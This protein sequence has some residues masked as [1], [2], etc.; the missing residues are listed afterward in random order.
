MMDRD[1]AKKAVAPFVDM[2]EK[3][4]KINAFD[5]DTVRYSLV[6]DANALH[7]LGPE[8]FA[9]LKAHAIRGATPLAGYSYFWNVEDYLANPELK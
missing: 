5:V 6:S 4:T 9:R 2:V 3:I 1:D 7:L 8:V